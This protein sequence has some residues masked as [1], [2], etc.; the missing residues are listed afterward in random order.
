[1]GIQATGSIKP[2]EDCTV[3]K[4]KQQG[5][6]KKAAAQRKN[7]GEWLFFYTFS[8]STLT[9]CSKKHW[10]LVI[11]DSGDYVWSF[12]LKEKSDLVDIMLGFI[13]NLKKKLIM[14]V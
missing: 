7:Y 3:E 14:Q 13:K 2:C 9:F 6:S 8:T 11:G 1:M 5:V 12:F 4:A 10:L